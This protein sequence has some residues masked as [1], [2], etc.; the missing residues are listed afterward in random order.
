[1]LTVLR[2]AAAAMLALAVVLS[3]WAAGARAHDAKAM[4]G[5]AMGDPRRS[6]WFES[7]K[8]P[9]SS[10]GCCNLTDC[11]QTEARQLADQSWEAVLTDYRGRRWVAIPPGKVLK[12]P[13]SV[14]GE[15]YIC[16]TA[17]SAGGN[18]Y[19]GSGEMAD[20]PPS[21]GVVLCFIPPIPGY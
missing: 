12:N 6:Q 15:A 17:G 21:D 14:D 3:V 13:K 19:F 11:R 16:N 9:G 2:V 8:Q 20:M 10:A 5:E 18:Q 4:A 1:M 7:L